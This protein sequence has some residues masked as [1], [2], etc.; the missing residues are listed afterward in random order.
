MKLKN[1]LK[2]TIVGMVLGSAFLLS[3]CVTPPKVIIKPICVFD[4][5]GKKVCTVE[6]SVTMN[7]P[8]N[9]NNL[10]Q[11]M[12]EN[13]ALDFSNSP[14]AL[15]VNQF[16]IGNITLKSNGAPIATQSSTYEKLVTQLSRLIV[17]MWETG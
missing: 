6:G 3:G 11:I 4:D 15:L 10:A 5:D 7:E 2:S 17:I 16:N 13:L 14:N 9:F 12:N 8:G 1:I